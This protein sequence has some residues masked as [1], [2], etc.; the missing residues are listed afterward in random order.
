MTGSICAL[1]STARI[2]EDTAGGRTF[3]LAARAH[4]DAVMRNLQVMAESTRRLSAETKAMYAE[5]PWSA[6]A[7][8]RNVLVHDYLGVDLEIVWDVVT[9]DVPVLKQAA[10]ALLA[11]LKTD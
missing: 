8:F 10:L 9:R 7:G 1:S 6:I 5:V 2:E 4:Q 3:F 11:T